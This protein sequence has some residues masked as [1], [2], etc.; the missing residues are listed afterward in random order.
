MRV[1]IGGGAG[2][3]EPVQLVLEVV[4]VERTEDGRL[5][6]VIFGREVDKDIINMTQRENESP[7]ALET[8]EMAGEDELC[9][10]VEAKEGPVAVKVRVG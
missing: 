1:Q 2:H 10:T 8:P 6:A 4:C 5:V 7:D 3:V 9:E